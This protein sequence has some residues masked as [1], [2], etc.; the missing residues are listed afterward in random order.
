MKKPAWF[1]FFSFLAISC[2]NEPDCYL[3]NNNV[4]GLYF[5]VLGFGS[6]V[7]P[8]ENI[9]SPAALPGYFYSDTTLT[10]FGIELNPIDEEAAFIFDHGDSVHN[11]SLTYDRKVQFVSEECGERYIFT[12]LK[13]NEYDF[14]SVQVVNPTPTRPASV[15]INI[16]RC[17]TT[18]QMGLTFSTATH[19]DGIKV[20]AKPIVLKDHEITSVY[21]PVNPDTTVTTYTFD[22]G[23]NVT[24]MLRVKYTA[25]PKRLGLACGIRTF[26]TAL[27][28]DSTNLTA[29]TVSAT[30]V[31]DPF[32]KNIDAT[33]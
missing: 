30:A 9:Q 10:E 22:F 23:G 33:K 20:D 19:V 13:V 31:V 28:I 26:F 7:M 12:D 1:V 2:L 5:R 6:D 15:N 25:T 11:L 29:A 4:I 14:D 32:V 27:A 8:I 17:P 21:L 3:L 18:N 24:K 16:F